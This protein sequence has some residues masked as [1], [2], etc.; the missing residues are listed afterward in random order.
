MTD[1]CGTGI[2]GTRPAYQ[3]EDTAV[4]GG[5][6]I[7]GEPASAG[8]WPW[9]GLLQINGNPFCGCTLICEQWVLTAAHCV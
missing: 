6:V 8:S 1:I 3:E 9:I 7:G 4:F 2:C 5:R